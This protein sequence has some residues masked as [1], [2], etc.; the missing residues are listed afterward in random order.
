MVL[1]I[2]FITVAACSKVHSFGGGIVEY[3]GPQDCDLDE[4]DSPIVLA[5]VTCCR[6][7]DLGVAAATCSPYNGGFSSAD[8]NT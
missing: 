6:L 2:N 4:C 1:G 5:A 3:L 7:M 8:S